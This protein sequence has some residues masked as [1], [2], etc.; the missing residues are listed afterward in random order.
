LI[1]AARRHFKFHLKFGITPPNFRPY[2][3]FLYII[4]ANFPPPFK[5]FTQNLLKFTHYLKFPSQICP[6]NQKILKRK[7]KI[8]TGS[9]TPILS[10]FSPRPWRQRRL[11]L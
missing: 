3:K 11:N 9:Q 2:S 10:A 5:K 8:A 7:F 1:S 6:K 4:L